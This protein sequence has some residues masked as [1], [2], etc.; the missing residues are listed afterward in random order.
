MVMVEKRKSKR[1][2][3][4]LLGVVGCL[5]LCLIIAIVGVVF[6]WV[7]LRGSETQTVGPI[8]QTSVAITSQTIDQVR[9]LYRI[10]Q[11]GYVSDV[12]WSPDGLIL[13]SAIFGIGSDP[14]SVELWDAVTGNKLH[15]FDQINISR[16]AFSPDGQL[17]AGTGDSG[18]IVWNMADKQ[19]L[20][21]MPIGYPGGRSV[22]F[23]PDSQIL[24]YEFGGTVNLLEMPDA[25][26]VNTLQH[27]SD[28]RGFAFLPD[29]QSL[30]T[31]IVSEQN[32]D[33]PYT[34]PEAT[35]TVWDIDSGRAVRTFTKL[36]DIDE[37]VI[38]P[39][40]KSLAAG[41]SSDTLK[42]W[43][44]ESGRDLQSFVGFR[45]GVPRF[46]FS[47]DGSVL[48][49]GEGVGFEV[50]SPSRLRLFDVASGREVPML[51]G[52]RSAIFSV[53][54]SPN[55]RL[56]ATASE[57]KTVRLWGVPPDINDSD[58]GGMVAEAQQW[59]AFR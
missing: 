1:A 30:I 17:L 46:A 40:G 16:L 6:L 34:V 48:G 14:G 58:T 9:E 37:L 39:D 5:A 54:F 7:Q 59:V 33:G 12:T 13:A 44:M 28:V 29:G 27:S 52:H 41:I 36:G 32:D 19:E 56:L 53:A 20:I 18:L 8:P 15:S 35:F 21:N 24:A 26:L 45:F 23:S 43:D 2:P 10:P 3:S 49:V 25:R 47:P 55:G 38:A 57:D 50:A 51:E 42:I 11:P 31:V 22:A 4:V